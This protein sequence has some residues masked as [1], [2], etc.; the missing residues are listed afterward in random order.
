MPVS[1]PLADLAADQRHELESLL[2]RFDQAW[3]PSLL[4]NCTEKLKNTDSDSFR[5]LAIAE[6][7]KID[8]YRGWAAGVGR[9]L[10]DNAGR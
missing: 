4:P 6:L 1:D 8:L 3:T 7:V 9:T 10:E 2:L 5:S